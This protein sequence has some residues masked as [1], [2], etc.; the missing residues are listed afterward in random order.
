[1]AFSNIAGFEV[2]PLKPSSSINLF[3]SPEAINF[4]SMLSF[5]IDCP[6]LAS[7]ISGLVP[8]FFPSLKKYAANRGASAKTAF[9]AA[10]TAF[11]CEPRG[12]YLHGR[13]VAQQLGDGRRIQ[14]WIIRFGRSMF[15]HM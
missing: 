10:R 14:G 6:S 2:T 5:Q 3:S 15:E 13:L 9:R 12:Y 1:M 8:M 4:R 11:A 7:S